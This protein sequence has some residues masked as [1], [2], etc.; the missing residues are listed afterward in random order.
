[1]GMTELI[2]GC[3]NFFVSDHFFIFFQISWIKKIA[4]SKIFVNLKNHFFMPVN[5]A[6]EYLISFQTGVYFNHFMLEVLQIAPINP[7]LKIFY[8]NLV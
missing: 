7:M 2:F 5:H 8:S 4:G 3:K 1:M 6:K